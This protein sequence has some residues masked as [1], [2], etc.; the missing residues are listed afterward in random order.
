ML[1]L[2]T[3]QEIYCGKHILLTD[4]LVILLSVQDKKKHTQ[5]QTKKT[6]YNIQWKKIEPIWFLSIRQFYD[7]WEINFFV[8]SIFLYQHCLLIIIGDNCNSRVFH[9]FHPFFFSLGKMT[10][11]ICIHH[12]LISRK[13]KTKQKKC[14][15]PSETPGGSTRLM[16]CFYGWLTMKGS[17]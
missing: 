15:R 2:D 12:E 7:F 9:W 1:G 3:K 8:N 5:K 16:K 10:E 17:L 6:L 14:F 4:I 13:K 11:D